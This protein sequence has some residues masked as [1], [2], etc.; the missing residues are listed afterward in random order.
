MSRRASDARGCW[1]VWRIV[2]KMLLAGK[3]RRCRER[4]QS[5]LLRE[6]AYSILNLVP[7]AALR[8]D[9]IKV[10]GGL[11]LKQVG[12]FLLGPKTLLFCGDIVSAKLWRNDVIGR[13]VNEPLMGLRNGKLQGI[14]FTI[15]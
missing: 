8:I 6:F 9:Q 11:N 10:I 7:R 1:K 4:I 5:G 15:V 13:S 14:G 2:R 12:I 3:L